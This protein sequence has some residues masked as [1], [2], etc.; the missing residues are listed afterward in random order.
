MGL[1]L[2]KSKHFF[3]VPARPLV[4]PVWRQEEAQSLRNIEQSFLGFDFFDEN[5]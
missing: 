3:H 1:P 4:G 5:N 2:S